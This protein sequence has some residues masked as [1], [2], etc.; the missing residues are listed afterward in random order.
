LFYLKMEPPRR[1]C[2]ENLETL[3]D[4]YRVLV[5][6]SLVYSNIYCESRHRTKNEMVTTP[7]ERTDLVTS[8]RADAERK[9]HRRPIPV[10]DSTKVR[11]QYTT[12]LIGGLS[13]C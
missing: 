1:F 2:F 11:S 6:V 8:P 3:K 12:G 9:D 13:F 10:S 4:S 5:F 7:R